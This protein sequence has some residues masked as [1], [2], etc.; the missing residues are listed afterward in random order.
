MK[1]AS[2]TM[3]VSGGGGSDF[4]GSGC[5]A[6][7]GGVTL[8]TCIGGGAGHPQLSRV[9]TAPL[10]RPPL[11]ITA[12]L[13][14][15]WYDASPMPSEITMADELLGNDCTQVSPLGLTRTAM[16]KRPG[17]GSSRRKSGVSRLSAAAPM[18]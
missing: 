11:K 9:G 2:T 15:T 3:W 10:M 18:G 16:C 1:G 14:L 4:G 13:G 5:G 7:G 8:A 17:P 6:A 12:S